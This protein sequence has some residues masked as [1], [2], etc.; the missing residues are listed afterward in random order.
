MGIY[1]EHSIVKYLGCLLDE[2]MCWEAVAFNVKNKINNS[3]KFIY[4]NNSLST[5]ALRRLLST[6]FMQPHSDYVY[7]AWYSNLTSNKF[8]TNKD[9]CLC[10]Y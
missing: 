2:T 6:A 7:S 5:P 4:G 8:Q 1:K 3:L 9:K 10:F